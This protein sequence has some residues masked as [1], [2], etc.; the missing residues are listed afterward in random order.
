MR[1]VFN[2]A[3]GLCEVLGPAWYHIL[4]V[5]QA[6]DRAIRLA[7]ASSGA[8]H[9]P[10]GG[11]GGS[12]KGGMPP[13]LSEKAMGSSSANLNLS[14][15]VSASGDGTFYGGMTGRATVAA[16]STGADVMVR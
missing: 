12:D 4:E 10:A 13:P 11:S 8:V 5:L 1:T 3:Q 16:D 7:S 6:V 15:M 2:V 14:A 9:A